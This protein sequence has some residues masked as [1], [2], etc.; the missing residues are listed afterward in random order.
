[1]A[2]SSLNE[3]L[4]HSKSLRVL[5][6]VGSSFG[7]R[8]PGGETQTRRVLLVTL[9][10]IFTF[11]TSGVIFGVSALDD[12]LLLRE[13]A[14]SSACSE[15]DP[16]PC[17]EQR[18]EITLV[19]I[20]ATSAVSL[21]ILPTGVILDKF[22]P[23][24]SACVGAVVFG[25]GLAALALARI[26]NDGLYF[27]GFVS[28][29]IGGPAVFTSMNNFSDLFPANSPA[30][31]SLQ[32]GAFQ[33]SAIL[34]ELGA[35]AIKSGIV[36]FAQVCW[37]YMIVP[38]SLF[39]TSHFLFPDSAFGSEEGQP[40]HRGEPHRAW[41]IRRLLLADAANA[42]SSSGPLIP[43]SPTLPPPRALPPNTTPPRGINSATEEASPLFIPGSSPS[44]PSRSGMPS[45]SPTNKSLFASRF[46]FSPP[47]TSYLA[48][49]RAPPQQSNLKVASTFD[50]LDTTSEHSPL[51]LP[52]LVEEDHVRPP[53][54]LYNIPLF[55]QIFSVPFLILCIYISFFILYTNFTISSIHDQA[56]RAAKAA[57]MNDSK[58]QTHAAHLNSL[59]NVLSPLGGLVGIPIAGLLLTR[60]GL[61]AAMAS[62]GLVVMAFL[63]S[64]IP[65]LIPLR[66][67]SIGYF[68]FGL[69]RPLAFGS[70][71]AY[72]AEVFGFRNFGRLFGVAQLTGSVA[73]PIQYLL[74]FLVDAYSTS[75]SAY[76]GVNVSL[77]LVS[78]I[79]TA[80]IP[81][82]LTVYVFSNFFF[83]P[84]LPK[85]SARSIGDM[86][87]T[88]E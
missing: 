2:P 55:Q 78:L 62:Q 4:R 27:V 11:F 3:R 35:V 74:F 50:D 66:F 54:E 46:S 6:R 29:A 60:F 77:T 88:L 68:F 87:E 13:G 45:A 57:G 49:T 23:R 71:T 58:A 21:C 38:T 64:T 18:K 59:F 22:G 70:F 53:P 34:M 82:Y 7:I 72:L 56:I 39:L 5:Y 9:S 36:T 80:L 40:G 84:S 61:A 52:L 86:R 31:I 16:P 76:L 10:V 17:A 43:P 12:I 85:H 73:T 24:T 37:L 44:P 15:S 47:S 32:S 1:M 26:V 63:V 48:D 65:G 25:I 30:I 75:T 79:L 41:L 33:V 20:A 19:I 42:S 81:W 67:K 28:L 51:A 83:R 8:E 14:F 69:N